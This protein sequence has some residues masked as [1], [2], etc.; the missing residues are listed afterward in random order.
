MA[1]VDYAVSF[2]GIFFVNSSVFD[3]AKELKSSLDESQSNSK[4]VFFTD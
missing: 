2:L 4:Q 1:N 3:T